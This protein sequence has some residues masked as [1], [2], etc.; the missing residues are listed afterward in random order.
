MYVCT[1]DGVVYELIMPCDR[2]AYEPRRSTLMAFGCSFS[3]C[4]GAGFDEEPFRHV[5]QHDVQH[6]KQDGGDAQKLCEFNDFVFFSFCFDALFSDDC[7][8]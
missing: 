7:G 1:H 6:E 5:R 8:T 2:V 4:V 3:F